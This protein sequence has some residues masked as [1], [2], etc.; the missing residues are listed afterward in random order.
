M[1]RAHEK[2]ESDHLTGFAIIVKSKGSTDSAL[3]AAPALILPACLARCPRTD[4]L[5]FF[6]EEP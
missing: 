5:D 6:S 2:E 4:K 3:Q 1:P